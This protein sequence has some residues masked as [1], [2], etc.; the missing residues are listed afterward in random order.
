MNAMLKQ[1][2]LDQV[3]SLSLIIE[4]IT[5]VAEYTANIAEIVLNLNIEDNLQSST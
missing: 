2:D 4:S 5:R 1:T 3:S